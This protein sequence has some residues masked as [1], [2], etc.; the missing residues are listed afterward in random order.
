MDR[1][2]DTLWRRLSSFCMR[3]FQNPKEV[4]S[5]QHKCVCISCSMH[6]SIS[7]DLC[8]LAHYMNVHGI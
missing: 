7:F 4:R 5:D 6:V 8:D 1:T 3:A 2:S